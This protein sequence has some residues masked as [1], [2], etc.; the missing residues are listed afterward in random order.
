[1]SQ[2]PFP[3]N[4]QP[5]SYTTK[6][7][8]Q[9]D[10]TS[11]YP[12]VTGYGVN[13][14]YTPTKTGLTPQDLQNFVGIPLQYYQPTPVPVPYLVQ[15]EWIR[16]AEDWVEQETGLL[17]AP[18]W[19]ASPPALQPR[20]TEAT[21]I[22]TT[23]GSQI[24]MLGQ[25]YDLADAAYD[26][27]F[28]RAQGE[29]WMVQPLRYRPIRNVTSPA[30]ILSQKDYTAVK[31]FSYIYPLLSEFFSVPRSWYVEDQDFGLIR[32]VPAENVQLLPLFAMQIAF[33]GFAESIPGALYLNYTCGLTPNDYNSRFR[34]IKELV[35][36]KASI[37]A[38]SSIQGTI[39]MGMLQHQALIDGV[40]YMAKYSETGPFGY[41][42]KQYESQADA[43]LQTALSKVSGPSLITL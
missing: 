36:A 33:M 25:D 23:S 9:W 29:G 2:S 37:R 27:F 26:F 41:Q 24:Q 32:L 35:L 20:T 13:G 18:T 8:W 40:S 22:K 31:G 12:V 10:T 15:Q 14:N 6:A 16:Y 34:F 38:L 3:N 43:L 1:M 42:I 7:L 21:N 17:L 28:P 30:R 39:S 19:V 5:L 11:E 4:L